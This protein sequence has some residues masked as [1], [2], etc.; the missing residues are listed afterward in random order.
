[1]VLHILLTLSV[2]N[3]GLYAATLAEQRPLWAQRAITRC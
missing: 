3:F 1:M 2:Y